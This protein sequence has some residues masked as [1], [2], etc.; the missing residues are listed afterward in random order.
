MLFSRLPGLHHQAVS[1]K[2]FLFY[3]AN[4]G[5]MWTNAVL[6]RVLSKD[7]KTQGYNPETFANGG[8]YCPQEREG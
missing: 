6:P 3:N 4:I 2:D 8:Y 1:L 5:L 7:P